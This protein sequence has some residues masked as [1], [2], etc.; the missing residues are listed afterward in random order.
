MFSHLSSLQQ[1]EEAQLLSRGGKRVFNV[2]NV[3]KNNDLEVQLAEGRFYG[4][5]VSVTSLF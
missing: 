3:R 5:G 1:A 2:Q 4:S